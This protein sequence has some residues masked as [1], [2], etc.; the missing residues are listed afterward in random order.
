[1]SEER[2]RE[3]EDEVER[4]RNQIETV[5]QDVSWLEKDFERRMRSVE[6]DVWDLERSRNT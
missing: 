1:M 2:I 5:K 6:N 3:L 4:L